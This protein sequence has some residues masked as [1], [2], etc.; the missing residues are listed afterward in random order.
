M[1][2]FLPKSNHEVVLPQDIA[3]IDAPQK[4]LELLYERGWDTREKVERYLNPAKTDLY[5]PFLMQ[6]M[7]KAVAV[8]LDALEKGEQIT[9]FGDYDV[10]GVTATAIVTTWLRKQRAH[11][12]Y[13]IP[14]RHG[15]GYG[16]NM[17]AVEEIA[18]HS[19][20]LITVDCGIT[21]V[22][23]VARARE[24]GMR[25]IVTDHHQ[26]GDMIPECEAVLDPLLGDY[27]FQRLCGAGVAFKLLQALGGEKA[28]EGLWDLAALATVADIVPLVDE[29]RVIVAN[30]LKDMASAKRP[31]IRALLDVAK[32]TTVPTSGDIAFKLAPRINAGGRLAL[33]SQSV[34]LLTTRNL[35]RAKQIASELD[36]Y[37]EKRK[38]LEMAIFNESVRIVESQVNFLED[39]IM[40]VAGEGWEPGVVG[41]AASRLVE[42][43][44]WP[45]VV[46][47]VN[48][49]GIC[50]G[51]A[52]SI[53]SVDIHK[54]LSECQDLFIRFGGHSQ[55]AGLTI[56]R[57]N[58]PEMRRRINEIIRETIDEKVYVPAQEYDLE[59]TPLELTDDF[60]QAFEIMQPIGY[61]NSAPVF[62]LSAQQV[63]DVR[64]LGKDNFHLRMTIG[65]EQRRF[66]A[67]WFR[68]GN[69][70]SQIPQSAD[71]IAALRIN[72]WRGE[73]SVQ[74][75]ISAMRPTWPQK[76]F[77][78]LCD[79]RQTEIDA[80]LLRCLG[81]HMSVMTQDDNCH[82]VNEEVLMREVCPLIQS[83]VQGTLIVFHTPYGLKNNQIQLAALLNGTDADFVFMNCD[84]VRSYNTVIMTPDWSGIRSKYTR[85]I[86]MDG[87]F[88]A[89]E[90]EDIRRAFG[91]VEIF[92][93]ENGRDGK[94]KWIDTL[95]S[96][97]DQLRVLYKLIRQESLRMPSLRTLSDMAGRPEGTVLAALIGF[98]QLQLLKLSF[99]PISYT[100]L[101]VKKIT[102]S[103]SPLFR[104][105]RKD[106]Q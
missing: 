11:V 48:E 85:V 67:I 97:D 51:S 43:Y 42:R 60:V 10:D 49:E 30:G 41:L 89:G 25:V 74:C 66:L 47:S 70:V 14:D 40:L 82:T 53:P 39:R 44:H 83:S 22:A 106:T 94:Q 69:M 98:D 59:V 93:L 79:T 61:G 12:D 102:L 64:C 26:L 84:D 15:E 23:E 50:V 71:F 100:M 78:Y 45:A 90:V 2:L 46:F 17:H 105:F 72:E 62:Y 13:Y 3:A 96:T 63:S 52:R 91:T 19:K 20:L 7:D 33:A 28:I 81:S 29:N 80:Y 55:A 27:P 104:M 99:D 101:P 4:L 56:R 54:V 18:A 5:D 6:D 38:E 37:N 87:I 77:K 76:H 75:E 9:V 58:I 88:Y 32:I 95:A 92:C 16:L 103:D 68:K 57:E 8:I 34:E 35:E 24:L 73:R 31:G 21:C 86:L 65:D 36:S 1:Q